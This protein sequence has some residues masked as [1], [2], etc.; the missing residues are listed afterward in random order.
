M[1]KGRKEIKSWDEVPS[2][3][4]EKEEQAWWDEHDISEELLETFEPRSERSNLP[5]P[6]ERTITRPRK[7]PVSVR[8]E[9]DLVNRLKVLAA[10]K[11]VG[12]QT[13]MRQFVADRVYEEEKREG[14]IG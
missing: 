11:G 3:A 10:V 12:Y 1:Q 14:I 9:N 6:R 4:S 13:L 8:M 2:F 5:P 7:N